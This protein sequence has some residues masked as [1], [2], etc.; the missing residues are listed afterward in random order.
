MKELQQIKSHHQDNPE[1]VS[2]HNYESALIDQKFF[3]NKTE[4]KNCLNAY[5]FQNTKFINVILITNFIVNN[6][7]KYYGNFKQIKCNQ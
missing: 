4:M 6:Y 3:F 1:K 7:F 5:T 2:F